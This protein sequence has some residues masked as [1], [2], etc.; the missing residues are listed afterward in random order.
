[1]SLDL[2]TPSRLRGP[3]RWL[4]SMFL[5]VAASILLPNAAQAGQISCSVFRDNP[6]YSGI[7]NIFGPVTYS[8]P[9]PASLN[10]SASTPV[11][12][13]L[14]T[15]TGYPTQSGVVASCLGP[16]GSTYTYT[17]SAQMQRFTGSTGIDH[18]YATNVP[19]IGIRVY[20]YSAWG[21]MLNYSAPN[22]S[23]VNFPGPGE[24][25]GVSSS[26]QVEWYKTAATVS[27][28]AITPGLVG[29]AAFNG[30]TIGSINLTG[31]TQIVAPSGPTCAINAS[32]TQT[33]NLGDHA[34]ASFTGA[35][36]MTAPTGFNINFDCSGGTS[37]MSRSVYLT[38][39][40]ATVSSNR[41]DILN[42]AATATAKGVGIRIYRDA[43]A[44]AVKFGA[45]SN[46][47]GNPN[48]WLAGNVA[49]G[50][51]R[52][53]VPLQAR[54]IQTGPVQQGT[55]SAVATVTAAYN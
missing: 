54:L 20:Y 44:T 17:L 40:D 9:A 21:T 42:L 53:T 6:G 16:V 43:G 49:T 12:A 10:V 55:V 47:L 31:T 48:Q 51:P 50:T 27:S 36:S 14:A 19:G 41:T 35:G 33:V 24:A 18:V 15:A 8:I 11:G 2:R 29:T 45:E 4:A 25:I 3:S 23:T 22:S 28:G 7:V 46:N 32:S 13:V 30:A 37:G 38:M 26:V 1:M 39:T 5:F 34:A 52:F